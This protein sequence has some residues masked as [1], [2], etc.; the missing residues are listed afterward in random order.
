MSTLGDL[1]EMFGTRG[2]A[3]ATAFTSGGSAS[4]KSTSDQDT[5]EQKRLQCFR[6]LSTERWKS[7]WIQRNGSQQQVLQIP[8]LHPD[9]AE[10][11]SV[12]FPNVLN[13]RKDEANGTG[14]DAGG[15]NVANIHDGPLSLSNSRGSH[16]VPLS[17]APSI[18]G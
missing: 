13:K 16:S 11:S 12:R 10:S 18:D 4:N 7:I 14:C 6:A 2:S 5:R 1:H 9:E 8:M 3:E 17:G 15:I